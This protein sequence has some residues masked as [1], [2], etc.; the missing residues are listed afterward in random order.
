MHNINTLG[1]KSGSVGSLVLPVGRELTVALV[2]ASKTVDARLDE[3]KAEL[4]VLVTV[5]ALKMLAHVHGLTDHEVEILGDGRGKAVALEDAK[6]RG[7]V[8]L[9]N[10]SNT[11]GVTKGDTNLRGAET[12]L[13]ELADRLLGLSGG[14]LEPLGNSANVGERTA[15][16]N[17]F[18]RK[19]GDPNYFFLTKKK[20]KKAGWGKR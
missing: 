18:R 15:G 14:T 19:D 1:D 17:P 8:K 6:D 7:T 5:V 9:L 3:D 20:G 2:V 16:D 11:V 13:G 4:G 10:L 12:L